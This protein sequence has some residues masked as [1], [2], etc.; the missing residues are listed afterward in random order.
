MPIIKKEGLNSYGNYSAFFA[1]SK[2]SISKKVK[3]LMKLKLK[4]DSDQ[5]TRL[6]FLAL[7]NILKDRHKTKNRLKKLI[8]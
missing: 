8:I 1:K 5:K 7:R 6:A 2:A 4:Q 3:R